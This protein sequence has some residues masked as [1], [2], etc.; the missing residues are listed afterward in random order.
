MKLSN[1]EY[2][3]L[4]IIVVPGSWGRDSYLIPCKICGGKVY[5]TQFSFKRTY[6]CNF[7]KVEQKKAHRMIEKELLKELDIKT[8]G[9]KRF[10]KALALLK[11]KCDNFEVYAKAIKGARR[12]CERYGSVPEVIVAIELLRQG[13]KITPQQ[14]VGKYTVDFAIPDKKM[15]IEVDGRI[16][17]ADLQKEGYRDFVIKNSLGVGWKIVHIPSEYVTKDLNKIANF[18]KKVVE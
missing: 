10:E 17:H 2:E 4:G 8:P 15:V 12:A 18:L 3:K 16:Y 5:S 14:R 13:N 9:E 1:E 11:K 7:C 6:I